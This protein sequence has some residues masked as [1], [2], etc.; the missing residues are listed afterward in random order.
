MTDHPIEVVVYL[1]SMVTAEQTYQV[2]KP[3]EVTSV[4]FVIAE[5]DDSL[6]LAG[7]LI[8]A[9]SEYRAQ[10]AIPKCAIIERRACKPK[11]AKP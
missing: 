11:K 3:T 2:A 7:E 1:D 5:D 9:Y 4:G 8:G 10:A 6:T